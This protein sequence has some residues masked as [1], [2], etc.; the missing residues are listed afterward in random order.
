MTATAA[1]VRPLAPGP[2]PHELSTLSGGIA[3]SV[4]MLAPHGRQRETAGTLTCMIAT[5]A[6]L[7]ARLHVDHG[8]VSSAVCMAG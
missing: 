3:R 7:V 2:G 4:Q 6:H 5:D 1:A 8:H